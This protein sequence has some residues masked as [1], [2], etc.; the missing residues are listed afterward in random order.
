MSIRIARLAELP[1]HVDLVTGW[2]MQEWPEP[3][4]SFDE[5]RSR[6]MDPPLCPPTLLAL[7]GN[8]A[9]GVLGFARFRRQG[10]ER[11]SLFIDA[12]F[13]RPDLR[14]Q[15]AGSALLQEAETLAAA[16]ERDLFVYTSSPDWYERRGWSSTTPAV[17]LSRVV[18]KRTVG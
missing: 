8:N 9:V 1:Q 7:S 17:E 12:L 16:H 5:R 18:L 11:L 3:K 6:L 15:G 13:V 14:N 10:D 4:C 2:L